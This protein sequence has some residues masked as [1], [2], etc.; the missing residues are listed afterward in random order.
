MSYFKILTLRYSSRL[1]EFDTGDFQEFVKDKEIHEVR[2][3]FF[4]V[5]GVPH[6][7]LLIQYSVA[8]SPSGTTAVKGS[9]KSLLGDGDWAVFNSLRD[10]RN[11]RAKAKGFPPYILFDNMQLA[12]ISHGCPSSKEALMK[13]EGIGKKKADEFWEDIIQIIRKSTDN[14]AE[15]K[16]GVDRHVETKNAP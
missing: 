5:S 4:T 9:Y 13:I 11:A 15:E 7:L 2:E 10:W 16:K 3:H 12:R 6:V 14:S 8:D 1:L